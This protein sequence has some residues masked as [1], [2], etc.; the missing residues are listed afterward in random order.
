MSFKMLD[1]NYASGFAREIAKQKD[2]IIMEQLGDL[3]K[4]GLLVV[5]QGEMVL[6]QKP[7]SLGFEYKQIIKLKLRDAEV[8]KELRDRAE[9][10][11]GK[12]KKMKEFFDGV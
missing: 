7:D 3:V 11:E 4:E 5:E 10:A 12:L 6:M 2:S 1:P 9:V 8:F